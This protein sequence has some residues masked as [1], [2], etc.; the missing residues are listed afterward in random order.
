MIQELWFKLAPAEYKFN[1]EVNHNTTQTLTAEENDK[2]S[3]RHQDNLISGLQFITRQITSAR[4]ICREF[5]C[6]QAT[7]IAF[8]KDATDSAQ[9]T[10]RIKQYALG[11]QSTMN[12]RKSFPLIKL[13]YRQD[14]FSLVTR[15]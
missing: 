11:Y 14:I 3:E 8:D 2:K 12:H 1:T 6:K 15:M 9:S 4:F 10:L 13:T 5:V 7:H